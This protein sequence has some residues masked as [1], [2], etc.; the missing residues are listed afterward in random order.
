MRKPILPDNRSVSTP[1]EVLSAHV[2]DD[3]EQLDVLLAER[4]SSTEEP[5]IGEVAQH[6]VNAGGKRIRP[7]LTLATARVSGYQGYQHL[8]LAAA[9][10]LL[11]SATLLHDDVVDASPLRRGETTAHMIWGNKT[12]ILV[13]DFLFS[14]SFALMVECG[15][16]PILETL[17][18]AAATIAE[19][20]VMQ[21]S[22]AHDL[23]VDDERYLRVL[24]AKTAAMFGAAA[25]VGALIAGCRKDT[26]LAFKEYGIALGTAFQLADDALDYDGAEFHTGKGVGDDFNEGKATIPA[27]IA[28]R[29]G[30]ADERAFWRR[31]I[32]EGERRDGDLAHALALADRS[33]AVDATRRMADRHARE[34]QAAILAIPATPIRQ[35]LSDLADYAV[36]RRS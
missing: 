9:V 5:L 27:L 33:G 32:A 18:A 4:L 29:S 30:N 22:T 1:Y 6:L 17:A 28:Y 3:L 35:A 13:G 36:R 10:E 19:G 34:A 25:E 15:S 14:R 20:E 11:H 26:V 21:L 12:S 16:L 2:R 7:L 23:D 24:R 8:S 31:T